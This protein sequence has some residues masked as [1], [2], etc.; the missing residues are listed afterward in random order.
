[1]IANRLCYEVTGETKYMDAFR[2]LE[3]YVFTHF[4]DA[5]NG[6]WY[7]YMHYDGTVANT[8]KGNI[9]KGLFHL[10]RM[11]MQIYEIE[12]HRIVF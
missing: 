5:A 7:G 2:R 11:L 6:E 12:N 1:M 3:N 4:A 9:S 8:L 10:P